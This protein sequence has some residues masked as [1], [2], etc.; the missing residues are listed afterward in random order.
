IPE[1]TSMDFETR[2]SADGE[3]WEAWMPLS[4]DGRIASINQQFVQIRVTFVASESDAPILEEI[5][6]MEDVFVIP[7]PKTLVKAD[8]PLEL[9]FDGANGL[10]SIGELSNAHDIILEE[11]INGEEKL[12]FKLPFMD[13]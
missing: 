1:G 4:E 7:K 12:T 2:T 6:V 10:D 8:D 3:T 9:F 13:K 5:R 11:E